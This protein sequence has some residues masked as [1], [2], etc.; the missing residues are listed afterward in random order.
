MILAALRAAVGV[1]PLTVQTKG[2]ADALQASV[3]ALR[4]SVDALRVRADMTHSKLSSVD[5]GL[6]GARAS[7][8]ELRHEIKGLPCV[9]DRRYR[10]TEGGRK[11]RR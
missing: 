5:E 9:I 10:A 2:R 4:A 6:T 11:R 8:V 3:D 7:I 1:F